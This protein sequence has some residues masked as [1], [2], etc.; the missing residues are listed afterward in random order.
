MFFK[1]FSIPNVCLVSGVSLK[2]EE[3]K[4]IKAE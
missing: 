2:N 3:A 4:R 1:F